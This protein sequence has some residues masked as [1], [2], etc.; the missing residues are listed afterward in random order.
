MAM[1]AKF[2][3][4]HNTLAYFTA[5]QQGASRTQ[6]GLLGWEAGQFQQPDIILRMEPKKREVIDNAINFSLNT[7]TNLQ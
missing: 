1:P 6:S 4:P 2:K 3:L 5:P 7:Q